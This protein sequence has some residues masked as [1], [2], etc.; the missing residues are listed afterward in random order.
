[1]NIE[2]FEIEG[3]LLITPKV[4]TD[5]RGDF[6]ESF[7]EKD[8]LS[9]GISSVF[10]Q[11]NQ[12]RSQKNVLRGLHFQKEPYA[13][14]KLVRVS[15]GSVLDVIVDLRMN[16]P[17]I[18]KHLKVKLDDVDFKMLW[19]PA[20][21]AHGFLSLEDETVFNYKCTNYYD[22]PSES[23]VIWNDITLGIEWGITNPIVSEK[24]L[25]LPSYEEVLHELKVLS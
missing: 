9:L 2:K 25:L 14:G 7:S 5:S 23:G 6:F 17:T 24:D 22:K 21:F 18:G 8:F 1:M 12:S 4:F 16:S 11:D 15:K 19:I 3:P 13:Q 20:G 10:V